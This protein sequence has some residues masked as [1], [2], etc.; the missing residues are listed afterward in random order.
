MAA[1]DLPARLQRYSTRAAIDS[2]AA[3]LGL[4]NEPGMQDWEWEVADPTRLDESIG[5]YSDP[6]LSEDERFTLMETI[7]QSCEDLGDSLGEDRR[8]AKVRALLEEHIDL[9][10]S[11]VWYW[12][13]LDSELFDAWR[14]S[15][16]MRGLVDKYRRRFVA[17]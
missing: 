16:F 8:W 15:P 4:R 3:R 14:V 7:I 1:I 11:S 9:H 13:S 12:A 6:E 10:I 5:A 17:D 2:L